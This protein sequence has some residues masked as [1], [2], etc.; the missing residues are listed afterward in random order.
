[1]WGESSKNCEINCQCSGL[2][3]ES[4]KIN[5]G[6]NAT[7][8]KQEDSLTNNYKIKM[9]PHTLDFSKSPISPIYTPTKRRILGEIQIPKSPLDRLKSPL[10]NS[11]KQVQQFKSPL[12]AI[13]SPLL[14]RTSPF[15]NQSSP[16]TGKSS[17]LS[18]RVKRSR[19]TKV[20]EERS[21]F[22]MGNKENSPQ[23]MSETFV[24]LDVEEETR[25]FLFGNRFESTREKIT[26]WSSMKLDFSHTIQKSPKQD[27]YVPEK[28]I[29]QD[30][31]EIDT[32]HDLEQEFEAD[33][34]DECTKYEIISTD[35]PD[36][37]S[38]G[39]TTSSRKVCSRNFVFGAPLADE[40]ASTSFNKPTVSATRMLN[41]DDEEFDFPSPVVKKQAAKK[42]LKFT[43]TPTKLTHEKSD[44]SI[45]SMSLSQSPVTKMYTTESTTSMESGFI[46]ELEEPFLEIDESNSPKLDNFNDLLS[47]QIKSNVSNVPQEK[48]FLRRPLNRSLSLNPESRA[49]VSLFSILENP[50]MQRNKKRVDRSENEVAN[51]R[52]R[53]NC[54]SP[55]PEMSERPQRPVLQRAYS[56]NNALIMSAMARSIVDPDLIG[57]FSVPYALPLTEG[58]HSDLK[59]I[60]CDTLAGLLRGE[61][62]SVISDFQI[63]DCRYPYEFEGGHIVNAINYYTPSQIMTLVNK[64]EPP[65]KDGR[66][67][68]VFHCEFS[69]ERGPKLSRFL[70]SSDRAKNKDRYPFLSYPEIYLLYGGY[71]AFHRSQPD[72]C[73]PFGYT[74][75]RDPKHA[76]SL[77]EHRQHR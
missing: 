28:E 71:Q 33:N 46:S 31:D 29:T 61:F 63:I 3:T 38:R 68:L 77:K 56:E 7:K 10:T 11:P 27:S 19:I 67:I 69:I 37:I 21:K 76:Q 70:R 39:R 6:N 15:L 43:E 12:Q 41:F 66:S 9:N 59:S 51:K 13:N 14:N 50:N 72:L 64:P 73:A 1:M 5:S 48:T 20:M 8:R 36:I 44:S 17:P 55:I 42:S 54:H 57:D 18:T 2:I 30:L 60:S 24:K 23:L 4:F 40:E 74:P 34:F 58:D 65:K 49:R 62:D 35:S 16:V 52:R 22:R 47:G 26:N 53:S 75:M 45:G 25:D 32:L